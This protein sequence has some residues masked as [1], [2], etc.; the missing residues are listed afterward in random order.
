M[1]N[2]L[3]LGWESGPAASSE[4]SSIFLTG[5]SPRFLLF[6]GKSGGDGASQI[7]A[8][9]DERSL[10]APRPRG[11][12]PGGNNEFQAGINNSQAW[13]EP[14]RERIHLEF[15]GKSGNHSQKNEEVSVIKALPPRFWAFPGISHNLGMQRNSHREREAQGDFSGG[16]GKATLKDQI[17]GSQT[18]GKAP[19]NARASE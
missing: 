9:W 11:R 5:T 15:P 8:G 18:A 7:P 6:Q 3:I 17:P 19:G 14:R 2:F 13:L 16:W 4:H 10:R 1:R 12:I